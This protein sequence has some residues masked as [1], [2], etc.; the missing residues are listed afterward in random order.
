MNG[1]STAPPHALLRP[2]VAIP[3]V[4]VALIWGSTWYVITG[5][6]DGIEPAWSIA[7]RFVLATPAMAAVAL[8]G[9]HSLRI[10]GAGQRLALAIGLTQFCGNFN[11]V[12]RAELHLTSGVVA[13]LFTLLIASNAVLA[14]LWLGE[15]V[16][17]RFWFG[18]TVALAGMA[19][20]LL[21]EAR[22]GL[23]GGNVLLGTAF[24]LAGILAASIANVVQAN[25]TG[26][27][28]PLSSLLAWSMLYGTIANIAL[29]FAL[30]G[31]P[32]WPPGLAFWGGVVWLALAGSVVTFP[33]YYGLI[34]KI[35]A[36]RAAYQNILVII[37]AMVISTLLENYRWTGLTIGGAALALAG[38]VIA[39]RARQ[40]PLPPASSADTAR[41]PSR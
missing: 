23:P 36:G 18:S 37:V 40:A 6:I 13:V 9:G 17:P 41:S 26:G 16:T 30:G 33:L 29:A 21:H 3:F 8:A 10:G 15:R 25:R 20:L 35:G 7:A 34:R 5:Q 28:L 22:A 12:Y 27:A 31:W 1:R 14:R 19:L 4:V 32:D 38:M 24:A 39:L 2:G 11:F